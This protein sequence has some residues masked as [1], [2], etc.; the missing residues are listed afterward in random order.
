MI[1]NAATCPIFFIWATEDLLANAV[2]ENVEILIAEENA[3]V[4][5]MHRL[6]IF[7]SFD[8]LLALKRKN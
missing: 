7:G 8:E 4:S 1:I 2:D 3:S 5:K 6:V